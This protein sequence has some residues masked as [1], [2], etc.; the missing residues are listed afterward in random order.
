MRLSN[1][2]IIGGLASIFGLV[3]GVPPA[4]GT[5]VTIAFSGELTFVED[6]FD[7]SDPIEVGTAFSGRYSFD[8]DGVTDTQ[9]DDPRIG[10]YPF[11]TGFMSVRVGDNVFES[12][13]IHLAIW[14]NL[15]AGSSDLDIYQAG[16]G[17][18]SAHGIDWHGVGL[19]FRN[20]DSGPFSSDALLT[21]APDLND[22]GSGRTFLARQQGLRDPRFAGEVHWIAEVPEPATFTLLAAGVLMSVQRRSKREDRCCDAG[23]EN[24]GHT[25]KCPVV[26]AGDDGTPC[27]ADAGLCVSRCVAVLAI[28]SSG[29]SDRGS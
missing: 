15:P 18:L 16:M 3:V 17:P 7:L 14:N 11:P 25:S 29:R 1:R 27:S 12:L 24:A 4:A 6:G 26:A 10:S 23:N 22:F 20:L 2:W 9:P 21:T 13:G 8:P 19:D 28:T 5:V